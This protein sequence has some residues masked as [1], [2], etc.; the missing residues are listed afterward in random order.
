MKHHSTKI[1]IRFLKKNFY[2][3]GEE[4]MKTPNCGP[5]LWSSKFHPHPPPPNNVT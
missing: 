1:D 2:P 4:F 5:P 3:D